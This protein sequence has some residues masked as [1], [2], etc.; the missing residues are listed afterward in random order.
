MRGNIANVDQAAAWD[1]HEGVRWAET[2]EHLSRA[3]RRHADRLIPAAAIGSADRVLDIGCGCGES[4][5]R[6][7]GL[8]VTGSALGVDLSHQ[9]LER[10]RQ[11]AREESLMNVHFEQADA[12]VYEFEPECYDVALSQFGGMFFVDP[13][14]AYTNIARGLCPGARIALLVWQEVEKNG[15]M[16]TLLETLSAGRNLPAPPI[17][18][19]GPFGLADPETVRRILGDAGY[20]DVEFEDV[21]E[22]YWFGSN[23]D[24][25]FDFASN[26]PIAKGALRDLDHPTKSHALDELA[27]ALA[28]C[29]T[30]EGV[31]LE[32]AS[33]IITARRT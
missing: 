10:A 29:E 33:W 25:A 20:A 16:R 18:T 23:L 24:D 8:A 22:P 11:R 28:G 26:L 15:W 1:G 31:L 3:L 7:A 17:G 21:R 27:S 6:A 9:M 19:P 2:E 14:A 30:N 4:T 12:Q 5:R 13:V 32:S